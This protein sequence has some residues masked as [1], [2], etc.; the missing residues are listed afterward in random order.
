MFSFF[1]E[2]ESVNFFKTELNFFA[3]KNISDKLSFQAESFFF[4][5]PLKRF[6]SHQLTKFL[7]HH[8]L[9]RKSHFRAS[10]EVCPQPHVVFTT[11]SAEMRF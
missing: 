6:P 1:N 10:Q 7:H 3:E 5:M 2:G 4:Y 9:T 8:T 11:A